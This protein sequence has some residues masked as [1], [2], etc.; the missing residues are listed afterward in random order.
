VD[1][2]GDEHRADDV[3]AVVDR[4]VAEQLDLAR[5]REDLDDRDV[6]PE[7]EGLV[8][9]LEEVGRLEAD[10]DLVGMSPL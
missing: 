5:I 6:R 4:D 9:R 2:T 7:R 1:L 10:L 3:A 8:G